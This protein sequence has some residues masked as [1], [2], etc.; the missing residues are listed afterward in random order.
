MD[1][2]DAAAPTAHPGV[3]APATGRR[4]LDPR[5]RKVLQVVISL[6]IVV[7]IFWYVLGQFADISEVWDAMRT[8]TW[9]EVAVLVVAATWNL[10]TYW[11]LTVIATPGLR[12][13]QA[14]VLTETTTAVS[15][16]LPA[17]GALGVGLTYT[18]LSSWGFSK[19]RSTLSVVVT[20]IWNN[21]AKLGL[22]IVAL[23]ILAVQGEPGGGRMVGAVAG[24]AGLVGAVVVFAL[25]LRS[26]QYARRAGLVGESVATRLRRLVRRGPVQGWDHAVVRFRNRVI[27]LVRQRWVAL[28][29]ATVVGHL[30]LY[31]VLLAALRVMG[32]SDADVG[33]AQVLAAFA[34]ARLLTAIPLTP[35]GV[36][37]IE[38]ALIA[39]LTDAGGADAAVVASVLIFRLLTYVVPILFGALTYLFWR[40]N[41][42]WRDT[43]PPMPAEL[44]PA[45]AGA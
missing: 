2:A 1:A 5:V 22:P 17:G 24:L 4:R 11:I 28:T 45:A 26:E 19:S 30:S 20:G 8:L 44:A 3:A 41:R 36:G 43:A 25:I 12:Y 29:V 42:S 14:V 34:F 16:A 38:L 21:F 9:R 32:V 31:A 37:I 39:S 15:N 18:M 7:G 27:G 23:A 35:G 33:W 40:R 13:P 10:V 6:A